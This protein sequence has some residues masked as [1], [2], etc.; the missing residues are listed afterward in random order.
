MEST[1]TQNEQPIET[2]VDKKTPKIEKEKVKKERKQ[3][4]LKD[5]KKLE[6]VKRLFDAGKSR[7]EIRAELNLKSCGLYIRKILAERNA[8]E[9]KDDKK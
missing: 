3:R 7:A 1:E 6:D 9:K 5:P 8:N 4:V 2:V